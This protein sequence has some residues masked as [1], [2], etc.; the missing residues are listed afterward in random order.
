MKSLWK[1]STVAIAVMGGSLAHADVTPGTDAATGS[2]LVLF[3]RDISAGASPDRVYARPLD[4]TVDNLLTAAQAGGT[5][6][7]PGSP[8]SFTMPTIGPDSNLSTFLG[9]GSQFV[10]TIMAAD[11][12][13]TAAFSQRYVTTT[14]LDLTDPTATLPSNSSLRSAWTKV[15]AMFNPDLNGALPDAGGSTSTNGLWGQSGTAYESAI[16]W[17][18][19]GVNNVNALGQAANLYVLTN[20]ST[21][22]L[23][24]ARVFAAFDVVLS[25]TGELSAVVAAV[26]LPP[27]LLLL[28]SAFAG[29]AGVARRRQNKSE[30]QPA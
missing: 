5:Y 13:G 18:G 14:Q 17:F 6:A 21:Q 3:V 16:D 30:A 27:A 9:Q 20:S 7:G 2:A 19:G 8:I 15:G 24:L 23:A 22:N 11:N 25:S 29:F 26:P 10:W 4:I 1:Y 28:G 12:V